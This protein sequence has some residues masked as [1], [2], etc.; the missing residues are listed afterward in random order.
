MAY[1]S[2]LHRPSYFWPNCQFSG[3]STT[4][5]FVQNQKLVLTQES[6]LLELFRVIEFWILEPRVQHWG[7]EIATGVT[8]SRPQQAKH[9]PYFFCFRCFESLE[10]RCIAV[11]EYGLVK[12]GETGPR[13]FC[14]RW[15]ESLHGLCTA[16]KRRRIGQTLW[17]VTV[18]WTHRK[19]AVLPKKPKWQWHFSHLCAPLAVQAQSSYFY[20]SLSHLCALTLA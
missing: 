15:F 5:K 13:F 4:W 14:F 8:R 9:E 2:T 12:L 19:I 1:F 10:G 3:F 17:I 16:V 18:T 20:N 6:F 7:L 11:K